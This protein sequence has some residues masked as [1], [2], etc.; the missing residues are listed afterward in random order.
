LRGSS[1]E[2]GS[3][4]QIEEIAPELYKIALPLPSNHLDRV[5][6]YLFRAGNEGLL[7]DTGW[8]DERS[9]ECLKEAFSQIGF[10][11]QD[12]K[13]I[14]LSHLH[15]DHIGL[16]SRLKKE[17]PSSKVLMHASDAQDMVY[18]P[19]GYNV[20]LQEMYAF[21][22]VHGVPADELEKI[23]AVV[24][25]LENQFRGAARPDTLLKG[26]EKLQV[27]KWRIEIIAT[28]GHTRGNICMHDS[29]ANIFFSGDHILPRITPNV[30]LS[31]IYEGD[32]LGDYLR[33]LRNLK[34]LDPDKILPSHEFVF[35]H[36]GERIEE[37]E[38]HHKERLAEVSAA[39]GAEERS[40]FEISRE[41]KW[42]AGTFDKLSSWQKRAAVTETLAH[43]EYLKRNG[44]A[45]EFREGA[46]ENERVIY[47]K[48]VS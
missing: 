22:K 18:T 19:E 24:R 11:V 36:L 12:L 28:P 33:S 34:R 20:F 48:A 27:G 2:E 4:S 13:T 35:E 15:P 8:N 16:S 42:S 10:R 23:I 31:P 37:I 6:V 21:L 41:L 30:S 40:G 7:V 17:A 9:Y 38:A 32:P 3:L 39:L 5:F 25:P 29:S 45:L 46:A 44:K 14:V 26:G 47:T 43:L 1:G